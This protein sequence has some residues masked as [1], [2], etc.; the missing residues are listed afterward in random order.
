MIDDIPAVGERVYVQLKDRRWIIA[1]IKQIEHE[2]ENVNLV[3]DL[4]NWHP[5]PSSVSVKSIIRMEGNVQV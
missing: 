3:L 4:P 5:Y 1:S 2:V